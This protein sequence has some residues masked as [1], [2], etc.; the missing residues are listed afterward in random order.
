MKNIKFYVA[1][2]YNPDKSSPSM[3]IKKEITLDELEMLNSAFMICSLYHSITQIKDI[4]IENGESFKR[5]M[6]SKNL[7]E[8]SKN[9]IK[10]EQAIM[11][12]N[13]AVLNYASSIKT[14]IDMETRLLKKRAPK[15]AYGIFNNLCRMFYDKHIEYRFWVNFRNYIVHCEFPYSI[16]QEEENG[17]CKIVCTKE[18]LLQFDN[19]KHSKADIE[20]MNEQVDLPSLV[21]NMSSL[22]YA[23]YIDFFSHFTNIII[24]GIGIYSEFCRKYDVK[25]PVIIKIADEKELNEIRMQPLPINEL[26]ASFE[27]L[28][29]NPSIIITEK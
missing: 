14:Y 9:K 19:W 10:P 13:K 25:V 24:D 4:V 20:K 27:I 22:I 17:G 8:L 6:S 1:E 28:K 15:E 16:Y 21:D 12:A 29:N 26:K 3:E 7:M 23:F 2:T 11:L 5:Y 18:R